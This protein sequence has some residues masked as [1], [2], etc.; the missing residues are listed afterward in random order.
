M[1][2]NVRYNAI[3]NMYRVI[4]ESNN[5]NVII[6]S[7]NIDEIVDKA[8]TE[9]LD[10]Q[11]TAYTDRYR[12]E[13]H[14]KAYRLQMAEMLRPE[15]ISQVGLYLKNPESF[16]KTFA[17]R[18]EEYE[19]R[20]RLDEIVAVARFELGFD[21]ASK[22]SD[23]NGVDYLMFDEDDNQLEVLFDVAT[24][25]A[26]GVVH[27]TTG[28]VAKLTSYVAKLTLKG[29]DEQIVND[30]QHLKTLLPTNNQSEASA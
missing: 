21:V 30:A 29:Q 19:H 8:I 24:I 12:A 25:V 1:K 13:E 9:A 4:I 18:S 5:N 23:V 22:N 10:W 15:M 28:Y 7:S 3:M 6:E 20:K 26:A 2:H 14:Y 27:K 16:M 17:N 11:S